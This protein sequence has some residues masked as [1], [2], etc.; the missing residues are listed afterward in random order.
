MQILK[1]HELQ[2]EFAKFDMKNIKQAERQTLHKKLNVLQEYDGIFTEDCMDSGNMRIV[3]HHK[4][5]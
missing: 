4:I 3:D 1:I 2:S 5:V